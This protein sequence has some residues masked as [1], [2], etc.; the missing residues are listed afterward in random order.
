MVNLL[1]KLFP[2]SDEERQANFKRSLVQKEAEIGGKLFGP[3]P[4]GHKRQFFCLDENTWVWYEEWTDNGQRK[5]VTTRYDVRKTGVLKTQ[6]GH[7]T[8]VLSDHETVNLVKAAEIYYRKVD[9]A[10]QHMLA[11]S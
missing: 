1:P 11:T 4:K 5:A 10:Y 6:E 7:P 3:L 2:R 9:T 8:Q